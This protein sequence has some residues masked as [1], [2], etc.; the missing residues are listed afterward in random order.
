[1]SKRNYQN[2]RERKRS[3]FSKPAERSKSSVPV[4]VTSGIV[5]LILA[6]ILLWTQGG[7]SD[8]SSQI[9]QTL[10]PVADL[11]AGSS[12][13]TEGAVAAHVQ[14]G[15][16]RLPLSI[17]EDK[18][19]H[20]YTYQDG[21]DFIEFFVLK[22]SDGVVRAAFNACDVCYLEK[23]GYRQE[24]DEMVCNN[25]GQRFSSVL[26]NEVRGGCNPSPLDRTT[27]GDELVIRVKDIL[28]GAV[29]F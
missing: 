26:I 21:D 1:M 5:I 7:G 11:S 8:P 3:K 24:G 12:A 10:P 16:L 22:S 18:E 23:K 2:V 4:F 14:D 6:A 27:E 25:C 29:Y 15:I 19:A 9:E 20:F 28:A 17:F 13:L